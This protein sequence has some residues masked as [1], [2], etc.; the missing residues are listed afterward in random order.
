MT[1]ALNAA[2]LLARG[3]KGLKQEERSRLSFIATHASDCPTAMLHVQSAAQAVAWGAQAS[4]VH[5][6][7]S[8]VPAGT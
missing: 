2:L 7:Q 6:Q 8:G 3:M 4:L 5:G 1:K